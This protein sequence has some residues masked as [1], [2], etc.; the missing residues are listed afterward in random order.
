MKTIS[1]WPIAAIVYQNALRVNACENVN[2]GHIVC[3]V[4]AASWKNFEKS[5]K[6]K[7]TNK[8]NNKGRS[9]SDILKKEEIV[10]QRLSSEVSGKAKKYARV[11]P[12]EFVPYEYDELSAENIEIA[13]ARNILLQEF[14]K[15]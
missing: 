11:G 15:I 2:T 14:H 9:A 5:M 13:R 4:M 3:T 12:R 7:R 8:S 6:E 1:P 10:I